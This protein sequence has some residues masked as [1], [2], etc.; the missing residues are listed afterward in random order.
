MLSIA[1]EYFGAP[2][3]REVGDDVYGNPTN[4]DTVTPAPEARADVYRRHLHQ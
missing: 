2:D 4:D 1:S 3:G